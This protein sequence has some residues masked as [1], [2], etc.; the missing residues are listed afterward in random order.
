L[1]QV[2][3]FD[4]SPEQTSA[5]ENVHPTLKRLETLMKTVTHR[6]VLFLAMTLIAATLASCADVHQDPASST[7]VSD[8][9]ASQA[10]NPSPTNVPF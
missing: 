8:A 10:A 2:R 4:E 7:V 6:N 9:P 1:I 5:I 3:C